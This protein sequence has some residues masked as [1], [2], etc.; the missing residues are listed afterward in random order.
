MIHNTGYAAA[1]LP[2]RFDI[3]EVDVLTAEMANMFAA[4]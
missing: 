2:H 3:H 1:G 4:E